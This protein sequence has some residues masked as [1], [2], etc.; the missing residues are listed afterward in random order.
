M[1]IEDLA[2]EIALLSNASQMK[3]AEALVNMFPTRAEHLARTIDAVTQDE[4]YKIEKELGL[5]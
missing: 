1:K 2:T 4:I 5:H 3:L